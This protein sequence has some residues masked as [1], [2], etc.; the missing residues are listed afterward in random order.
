LVADDGVVVAVIGH[1][2]DLQYRVRFAE[3]RQHG[4]RVQFAA[5]ELGLPLLGGRGRRAASVLDGDHYD[6]I[7]RFVVDVDD[8]N[9]S[10]WSENEPDAFPASGESRPD[11][12]KLNERSQRA[13]YAGARV[14]W[15]AVSLD[16][17]VEILDGCDREFDA[18]HPGLQLV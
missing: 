4:V 3:Q 13:G 11:V 1:A 17:S 18:S 9:P 15:Q 14:S 8:D 6:A 12:R 7:L 2:S 16:Q 5:T 10:P